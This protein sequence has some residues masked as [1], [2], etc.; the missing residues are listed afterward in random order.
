MKTSEVLLAARELIATPEKWTKGE[1]A[2]A[3]DGRKAHSLDEEAV[4][5]CLVGALTNVISTRPGGADLAAEARQRLREAIVNIDVPVYAWNDR[6]ERTHA[7]V[8]EALT[9]AAALAAAEEQS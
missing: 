4:C 8:I 7:E 6:A 5:W 2:R 1:F 3:A 9:K